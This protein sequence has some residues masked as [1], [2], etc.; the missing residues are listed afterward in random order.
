M[1]HPLEILAIFDRLHTSRWLA[2]AAASDADA[3]VRPATYANPK[4]V[5]LA[6]ALVRSQANDFSFNSLA[7]FDD[8]RSPPHVDA[9]NDQYAFNVVIPLSSFTGGDIVLRKPATLQALPVADGPV[10]FQAARYEHWV[11]P[12][13]GRRTVLVAFTSK[14][15]PLRPRDEQFLRSLGFPLPLDPID[16][17]GLPPV[18]H[19]PWPP[20]LGACPK[21]QHPDVSGIHASR[22]PAA[23][24]PASACKPAAASTSSLPQKD[25][26][27][28]GHETCSFVPCH[29]SPR[30]QGISH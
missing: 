16:P 30:L 10:A 4:L 29:A 28:H 23:A 21:P 2:G 14:V 15:Q 8:L 6:V 1:P 17:S 26:V 20:D 3:S 5:S 19:A 11:A 9:R 22:M 24:V 27:I 12:W 13:R 18:F 7:I 25:P